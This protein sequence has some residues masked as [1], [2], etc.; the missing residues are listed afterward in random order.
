LLLQ[1]LLVLL[2]QGL[3]VLLLQ[4]LLVLLLQGLLLPSQISL[5]ISTVNCSTFVAS[6]FMYL[7]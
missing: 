6:F 3:L 2:L 5:S 4:G 1:G 7:S